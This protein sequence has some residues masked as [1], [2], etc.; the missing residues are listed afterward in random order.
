MEREGLVAPANHAGKREILI[1]SRDVRA[2]TVT[3]PEDQD[4]A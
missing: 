2:I 4:D 1:Y 3:M